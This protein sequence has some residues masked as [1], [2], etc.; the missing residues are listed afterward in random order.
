MEKEVIDRK[1]LSLLLSAQKSELTE[2]HI[3]NKLAKTEKN[4]RNKI[5]LEQISKDEIKHH[6]I[7]KKYTNKDVKPNKTKIWFYYFFSKL[8]GLTFGVKL[9][10]RGEEFSQKTYKK[11]AKYIPNARKIEEDEHR[12]EKKLLSMIDEKKLSYI[13][14]IV[15]GLND[16]LVELTAALT[17]L[18]LALQNTRLIAITGLIIGIAASFSMAASE[19][20]STKSEPGN[21]KH[22][23]RAAIYTGIT[24]IIT[25]FILVLPYFIV[26]NLFLALILTVS[27]AILII[28]LFTFYSSIAKDIPFKRR[29]FEMVF[30]SLGIA[31]LTFLIGLLVR[32]FFGINV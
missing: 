17:G 14:S 28:F 20:L 16:A 18:T 23:V 12:H 1:V 21:E 9:M 10:E 19:Y 31:L 11:I 7:W 32:N 3:Y 13:G 4:K 27:S 2:Y 15:L 25:V 30:L 8:L 22:P 29:F 26:S 5:I 24:Y 6:D